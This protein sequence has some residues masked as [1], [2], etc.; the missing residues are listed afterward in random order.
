MK[1]IGIILIILFV[2]VV[3]FF[4]FKGNDLKTNSRDNLNI[5][6]SSRLTAKQAYEKSRG[7]AKK[8]AEDGYLVD[9]YST[10]SSGLEK[11]YADGTSDT[12]YF[13]YFSPVKKEYM[14]KVNQ[15]KVVSVLENRGTKTVEVPSGWID[16]DK[17]AEAGKE[18]CANALDNVYFYNLTTKLNNKTF[19]W[20]VSCEI[21]GKKEKTTV[22]A[23]SGEID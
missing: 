17:V 20:S 4:I 5:L 16:T 13:I 22:D 19:V 11:S 23:F 18:K 3:G 6:G 15:G 7:E 8:Y 14:V 1:N 12:W 21:D 10:S 2:G 9:M